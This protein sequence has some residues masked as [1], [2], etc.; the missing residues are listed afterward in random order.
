MPPSSWQQLQ[1]DP[2]GKTRHLLNQQLPAVG[3]ETSLRCPEGQK[4]TPRCLWDLVQ[5]WEPRIARLQR[6]HRSALP[7]WDSFSPAASGPVSLSL[8]QC[9]VFSSP[10]MKYFSSHLGLPDIPSQAWL[11]S[12]KFSLALGAGG[13]S[14]LPLCSCE[15]LGQDPARPL[16]AAAQLQ[17]S[18]MIHLFYSEPQ[19][20][21]S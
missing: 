6:W 19:C 3:M 21:I 7:T 4:F 16:L 14:V 20:S 18:L 8:P 5:S 12:A 17:L 11:H 13:R 10:A 9:F 15:W 2:C 1:Q